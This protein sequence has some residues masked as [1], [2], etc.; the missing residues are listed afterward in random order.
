MAEPE[1]DPAALPAGPS[2]ASGVPGPLGAVLRADRSEPLR[3]AVDELP[4]GV[5]DRVARGLAPLRRVGETSTGSGG[6]PDSVRFVDLVGSPDAEAVRSGW[7]SSPERTAVS[8]G[9]DADGPV[10]VDLAKDGPHAVVAGTSGAGKSELLQT[11]VAGLVLANDPAHLNIIFMDYKGGAT[12]TE[13]NS[14]PHVVGSV[15]NLDER[16]ASRALSSLRAELTR[17]QAQLADAGAGSLAEYRRLA[18]AGRVGAPYPRLLIVVDELAEMKDQLPELV[19]GLVN[20]ARVGR[21]L[22]VHLVLA[23]QKPAGVVDS[24]IRAN[25]DLRVCLRVAGDGDSIDVIDVPDAARIPKERPGRALLVRGGSP[26][27]LVQTA[28]VT[29]VRRD[30]AATPRAALPLRWHAVHAPPPGRPTQHGLVTDL[31][32]QVAAVR[33]AARRAGLVAPYRPWL[34]PLP[35]VLALDAP[36]LDALPVRRFAASLGLWDRPEQQRQEPLPFE[37][38]T[39]HLAVVGSARTGRTSALRAVAAGLAAGAAAT[40]LH[41]HVI[42]GSGGLA[43]LAALPHTGVVA[44]PEDPPRL[45][46]LLTRLAALVR[47]R[48]RLLTQHAAASVAELWA[49]RPE[50]APPHVVLLVDD[51]AGLADGPETAA[52]TALFEL[53]TGGL[54]AGVTVCVAGDERLL[55]S[56]VIG[57][58]THRLC[59]RLNNPADGTVMGLDIRHLPAG[60]PAGRGLW[61]PEG[62]EVQVPL[63]TADPAGPAQAGALVAASLRAGHGAPEGPNAPLRLDPLPDRITLADADRTARPRPSGRHVLVGVG[64]DRLAGRWADL[65]AGHLLVA[66]PARSGRSTAAAAIAASATAAGLRVLLAAPRPGGVLRRAGELGL[67][68]LPTAELGAVLDHQPV[69]LVVVD[70][71][72]QLGPE[73]PLAQRLTATGGPAL[74][75]SALIESYGFGARGLVKAA[76]SGPTSAV[77]LLSPPNHL[78]AADVGVT[79]DRGGGFTGPAGRAYLVADG[80]TGLGQV[81]FWAEPARLLPRLHSE[82]RDRFSHHRV[83]QLAAADQVGADHRVDGAQP[84]RRPV[85][86]LGG[87]RDLADVLVVHPHGAGADRDRQSIGGVVPVAAAVFDRRAALPEAV[88]GDLLER[89]LLRHPLAEDD[90][91]RPEAL[92]LRAE[93]GDQTAGRLHGCPVRRHVHPKG[94]QAGGRRIGPGHAGHLPRPSRPQSNR[95]PILRP[96]QPAASPTLS[97][98]LGTSTSKPPDSFPPTPSAAPA[99]NWNRSFPSV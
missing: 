35:E 87:H 88:L 98:S 13:L 68:V 52:Q 6:I 42:D 29:T 15:T 45:E 82:R 28:R 67:T 56:R 69:D 23:T 53:L 58:F 90:H 59:L 74:A 49:H 27:R 71:A 18:T 54:A 20:V 9:A 26:P 25:V 95:P 46:R 44:D 51:W 41:L 37:L 61:S 31:Q 80:E 63:L 89:R 12:F 78:A 48:R 70:D 86:R 3:L 4:P 5:A 57:R 84:G 50:L 7:R 22:G 73:D 17:R 32:V 36:P 72:D 55:R 60:L 92:D 76:R 75:V 33:E 47:E 93:E 10:A 24:Q 8:I 43:G 62:T 99:P 34:P 2:G 11:L 79:L 81:R 83:V 16:L 96:V 14:L 66:G 39:G 40:E 19:D 77:V 64:G 65:D 94:P 97:A 1:I 38:G 91:V 85:G 30:D 21:S